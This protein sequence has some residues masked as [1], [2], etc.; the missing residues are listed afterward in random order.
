MHKLLYL[1]L[2]ILSS[3]VFA[4]NDIYMLLNTEIKLFS[5]APL[6]NIEATNKTANMGIVNFKT[7]NFVIKVPIKFFYFVSQRMEKQFNSPDY[8]DSEKYPYANFRGKIEGNYDISKDGNYNVFAIGNM[9]IHG[10]THERKIPVLLVVKDGKIKFSAKFKVKL[11]E[12]NI[13]I[14]QFFLR[15][16]SEEFDI[17]VSSDVVLFNF[18]KK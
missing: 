6:E 9:E 15:N 5:K 10:V 18:K 16:I 3:N 8:M 11:M 14:P 4:Q 17:S 2:I 7:Q 12:Y 13:K 1:F